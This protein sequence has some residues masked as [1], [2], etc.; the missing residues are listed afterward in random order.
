MRL[1]A[2]PRSDKLRD[3]VLTACIRFGQNTSAMAR[4]DEPPSLCSPGEA[5]GEM[6]PLGAFWK[7][8][9]GDGE[10]IRGAQSG[11][12]EAFSNERDNTK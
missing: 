4:L 2:S 5:H 10:T 3:D 12:T 9:F 8:F 7:H 11:R 6:G 1:V